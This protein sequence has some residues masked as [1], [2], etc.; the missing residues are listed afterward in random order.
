MIAYLA[1]LHHGISQTLISNLASSWIFCQLALQDSIVDNFLPIR[2]LYFNNSFF[3]GREFLLHLFLYSPQKEW[4][5][6]LMQ[7]IDYKELFFLRQL[8]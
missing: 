4:T 5:K 6:D 2:K 7:T 3:L 1:E 8:K